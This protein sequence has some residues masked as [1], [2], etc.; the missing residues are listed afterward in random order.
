MSEV[1]NFTLRIE[2]F[3]GIKLV[4]MA[5][6]G[7]E[8]ARPSHPFAPIVPI[9]FCCSEGKDLGFAFECFERDPTEWWFLLIVF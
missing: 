8:Q 1:V 6:G 7:I 3:T 2:R 4:N 9:V 5:K